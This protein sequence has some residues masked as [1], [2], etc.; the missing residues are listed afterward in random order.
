LATAVAQ[1]EVMIPT[2]VEL[3]AVAVASP[4]TLPPLLTGVTLTLT[5]LLLAA[6][7]SRRRRRGA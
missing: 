6:W 7:V 4:S 1:L 3:S 5:V 2:A